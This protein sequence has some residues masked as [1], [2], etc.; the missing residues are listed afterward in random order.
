MRIAL[1][2]PPFIAV[3]PLR[4][5]GTEL[6]IANLACE[7]HARGHDVTV[8]GNGDSRLPCRV[9]WR[10]PHTEWPLDDAVRSQL[11]NADHTAWAMHDAASWA[12]VVHLNDVVGLPFT[13]HVDAPAVLTIHHPHEP[14]LSE[15]YERYPDI[16]YVLIGR[17]LALRE[18]MPKLHVVHHGIPL[19][20]YVFSAEKD[21]YVAFLG[22]MAPCKGPHLA[23]AAARKAG[24]RLKLAGEVQPIF[25]EYWETEVLP[26]ID[27]DRVQWVGEADRTAKN[28]L[29][30][31]ARALLFPIQWEEPFGLVMIESMA[32]GTP[33][34]AL[35][36]GA[37][38]E[39]VSD[40]VNGWVCRDVD[41]MAARLAG[42]SI[43]PAACR[44]SAARDFSVERMAADYS[45]IYEQIAG[46]SGTAIA[47][48]SAEWRM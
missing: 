7:L 43:D 8:Y 47:K 20:Q 44:A 46:V 45:A 31:R 16:D 25:K 13:M 33:V 48:G 11:K 40:G 6:F 22:R 34:I 32:C 12:D 19:K 37:V 26:H 14:L 39:V 24:I 5:G 27:G 9:K 10:Y 1:I 3:P 18:Q 28:A 4:Y 2:S 38:E 29:L 41:E 35:P 36:G 23:I 15:Q 42:L 21:D 17:W 30:S